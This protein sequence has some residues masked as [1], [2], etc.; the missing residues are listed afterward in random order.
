MSE[1]KGL[2]INDPLKSEQDID[3]YNNEFRDLQKQLFQLSKTTFN[4]T[5]LFA[6]TTEKLSGEEARFRGSDEHKN[7]T[8]IITGSSTINLQKLPLLAA[9]TVGAGNTPQPIDQTFYGTG[10]DSNGN[11]V[12][13][14]G[15]DGNY[16][17]IGGGKAIRSQNEPYD[18][19]DPREPVDSLS[20]WVHTNNWGDLALD[21]DLSDYHK[22]DVQISF[23]IAS[24]EILDIKLNGQKIDELWAFGMS[25]SLS[26]SVGK[27]FE[28]DDIHQGWKT[29][30]VDIG[31]YLQDGINQLSFS[32]T[33]ADEFKI[34]NVQISAVRKDGGN[35]NI[36]YSDRLNSSGTIALAIENE[37]SLSNLGDVQ[38]SYFNQAIENIS[39]L[40]AQT[41]AT[42]SRLEFTSDL[43]Y[44]NKSLTNK[45]YGRIADVD[46]ALESLSLTKQKIMTSASAA[47]IAQA[48]TMGDVVLAM[49]N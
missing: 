19:A 43:E 15:I 40:W 49:L 41:T 26:Y 1:L 25:S 7:L 11:V 16:K 20:K 28:F 21:F 44:E 29:F 42:K 9:L 5:S 8:S 30:K 17:N 37:I 27:V 14:G 6:T 48:N 45:A 31:D 12:P 24:V 47:M 36:G 23:D 46:Y 32:D 3:A 33:K 13:V 22:D 38:M 4:G 34:K 2:S 39:Y 10:F 35:T 18:W